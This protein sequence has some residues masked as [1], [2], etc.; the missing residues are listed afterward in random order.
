[1]PKFPHTSSAADGLG[2][3]VYAASTT[4]HPDLIRLNVGDTFLLPHPSAQSEA[5]QLKTDPRLHNYPP[6]AGL[7][8]LLDAIEAHHEGAV[9]RDA[10]QVTPGAT[11]GL[12]TMLNTLLNPGEEVIVL[13]PF[14]PLIRGI[15][16]SRHARAVEVPFYDRLDAT[17]NADAA[18]LSTITSA[19]TE[20]TCALYINDPNNPTGVVLSEATKVALL[21]LAKKH[22]LWIV[23]DEAYED[24]IFKGTHEALWKMQGAHE[25]CLVA[26]TFSKS[27]GLAGARVGYVHGPESFMGA[28]RAMQTHCT[29]AAARPMQWAAAHAMHT[30]NGPPWIAHAKTVYAEA[31]QKTAEALQLP[32]VRAGT[33]VFFNAQQYCA[34][35]QS[36][37]ELMRDCYDAGVALAPGHACGASYAGY[38]RLCFTTVEPARLDI[39]LRRLR[40]VFRID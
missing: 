7:P 11:S 28:M 9:P 15:I 29:Y 8:Q 24:L 3:R 35:G 16:S 4:D 10:I 19:I 21:A 40:K 14:W 17:G 6:V 38:M 2:T 22:H 25:R 18:L 34:P 32:Q 33:F 37:E 39:A 26:H 13:A 5:Q 20:Q 36:T 27:Y 12:T 23:A 30:K 1:M 31:A